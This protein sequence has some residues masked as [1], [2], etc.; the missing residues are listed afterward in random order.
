MICIHL[1]GSFNTSNLIPRVTETNLKWPPMETMQKLREEKISC[2][3]L[4]KMLIQEKNNAINQV[5][6]SI[7]SIAD[8]ISAQ[9]KIPLPAETTN[10]K[11]EDKIFLKMTKKM[12]S[13]TPECEGKNQL[14]L[15]IQQGIINTH[16]SINWANNR[17]GSMPLTSTNPS[18]FIYSSI[19]I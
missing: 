15:R 7:E 16:F 13:G 10:S 5:A 8:K 14:K 17:H 9:N 1:N 19:H 11:S 18:I 3:V 6:E 12:V 4:G 2:P